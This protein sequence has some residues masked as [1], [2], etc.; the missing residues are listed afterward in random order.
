M[1]QSVETHELSGLLTRN[2]VTLLDIRPSA[3]FNGWQLNGETRGG[4]IPGA[5]S[6]PSA[7]FDDF[8]EEKAGE[9]FDNK[10]IARDK[11]IVVT[12]DGV[13]DMEA[14]AG[15]LAA[16]GF[17]S[18]QIHDGGMQGWLEDPERPVQALPRFRNLVHPAWIK[19][20]LDG[21]QTFS[22]QPGEPGGSR[23][24]GKFVLAHVS[25]DNW[26]DYDAGHI[27]GAIW[28]DT[29]ILEDENTWNRRTPAELEEELCAHGITKNTC[30]VLYGRTAN[31][32]MSQEQPGKEAG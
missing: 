28:I 16:L 6:F 27:P 30:V 22:E 3:A 25:F 26:G 9:Y 5:V 24:I 21:K 11:T 19:S 32:N 15:H 14:A 1:K 20:L 4:H 18:I 8:G 7:W 31:P 17:D 12:G 29:L 23:E 2:E 13:N 10:D